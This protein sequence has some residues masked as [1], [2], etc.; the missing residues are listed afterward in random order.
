MG[1]D[2]DFFNLARIVL[3]EIQEGKINVSSFL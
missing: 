3:K 2:Q 1:E